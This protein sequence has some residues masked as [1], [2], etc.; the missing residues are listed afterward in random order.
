MEN[1]NQ[2]QPKV[3]DNR[4]RQIISQKLKNRSK[5]FTHKQNISKGVEA[6]YQSQKA[7][8]SLKQK[9]RE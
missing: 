7:N 4:T 6:Y 1:S 9:S 5:S 8:N 3:V 2:N